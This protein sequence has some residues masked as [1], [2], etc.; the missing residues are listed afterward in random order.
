MKI[1]LPSKETAKQAAMDFLYGAML[2]LFISASCIMGFLIAKESY[3]HGMIYYIE[4]VNPKML[5]KP[6]FY[7]EHMYKEIRKAAGKSVENLPFRIKEEKTINAYTNGR[8]VVMYRGFLDLLNN[9]PD[10][11]A[12]V[13]AHEIAH[14]QL[15]HTSM[16][17]YLICK[18]SNRCEIQSDRLGRDILD[19]LEK[20]DACKGAIAF[21]KLHR[22]Y[23]SL[24]KGS[25]HP[26]SAHRAVDAC[27]PYEEID[28][29]KEKYDPINY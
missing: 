16:S 3:K 24:Y 25:S 23:G 8:E 5:N 20:Y 28:K 12:L 26:P 15:N 1:K 4:N 6:D 29:P 17:G 18:R 19:R 7:W 9:D 10:A 27:T 11:V 2:G 14:V 13:M 22:I 21:K